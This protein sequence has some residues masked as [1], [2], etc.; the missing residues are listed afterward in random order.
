MS[1]IEGNRRTFTAGG[2]I[3]K[4]DR[5]NLSSGNVVAADADDIGIGNALAPAASGEEVS[6]LLD[7]APGT[8]T[9]RAASAI[10]VGDAVFQDA[11]GEVSN[12]ASD[13][14]VGIAL[15]AATAANDEIEVLTGLGGE[16]KLKFIEQDIVI[17]DFTDN[18]DATGYVDTDQLLPAGAVP[19]FWAANVGTG[20]TGD[21]TAAMQAGIAGNLNAFTTTAPSVLAA[22]IV[23]SAVPGS[24]DSPVVASAAAVRLT[25][26][27]GADFGSIVA[28][29][30]TFKMA[31]VELF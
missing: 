21:T 24:G 18:G 26:T 28:G 1:Y 16:D 8:R 20:F 11:A 12:N 4:F 15:T 27:G 25:V 13:T 23:G 31:Y 19:L 10:A 14:F 9:C 2:T 29:A 7:N 22:A 6:V 3:N 17:G 30:M 5:V